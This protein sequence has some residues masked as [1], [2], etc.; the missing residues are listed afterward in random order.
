[1]KPILVVP[2]L[3]SVYC[4]GEYEHGDWPTDPGGEN[5]LVTQHYDTVEHDR[6]A[7]PSILPMKN[8]LQSQH[9]RSL[10]TNHPII[11]S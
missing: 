3:C 7:W 11:K 2:A 5:D 4:H 8:I 10:L 9:N 1:M 6:N